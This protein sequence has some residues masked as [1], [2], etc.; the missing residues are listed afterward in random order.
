MEKNETVRKAQEELEYLEGD[1]AFKRK[2][3]LK[4]KY[5]KDMN[6]VIH[7]GRGNEK[8]T[9]RRFARRKNK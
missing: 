1:E 7:Y 8:R 5:E 9:T 3:E 4:E 2:V 6:S